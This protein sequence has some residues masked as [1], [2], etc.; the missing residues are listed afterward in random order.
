MVAREILA[1]GTG[2]NKQK[3]GEIMSDYQLKGVDPELWKRVKVTCA[4]ND[5]TLKGFLI[6]AITNQLESMRNYRDFDKQCFEK[7]ILQDTE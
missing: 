2:E 1:G 5:V 7:G 6:A 3:G 4:Q